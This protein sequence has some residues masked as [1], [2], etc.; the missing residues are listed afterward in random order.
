MEAVVEK[1]RVNRVQ[2]LQYAAAIMVICVH[3]GPVAGTSLANYMIKNILCRVAVPFFAVSTAYF[4]RE[5]SRKRPEYF[6]DYVRSLV[7]TYFVWSLIFLPLGVQW[8]QQNMNLPIYLYPVALLVGM[9]YVGTYY[10]L[11]YIPAILFALC[12]VQFLVKRYSYR[13]I[14]IGLGMLYLIGSLETYYGVLD[15][16]LIKTMFDGY[17]QV[18]ITTRNG[19]LFLSVFVAVGYLISDFR[20]EGLK[21]RPLRGLLV[22]GLGLLVEGLFLYQSDYLDMN[23]LLMLVPVSFYLFLWAAN[24]PLDTPATKWKHYSNY[25]YFLHPYAI[26]VVQWIFPQADLLQFLFVVLTTH[27]MSQLV[28]ACLN[29][30]ALL[31]FSTNNLKG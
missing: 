19:L 22:S 3:C 12:L 25:Y 24:G 26:V 6:V 21:C 16:S 9:L 14:L 10:H 2:L 28:L 1:V 30:G 8:I 4:V 20:V 27:G 5:K 31:K 11:W 15:S 13:R 7:K 18:F 29:R 23:F 17:L